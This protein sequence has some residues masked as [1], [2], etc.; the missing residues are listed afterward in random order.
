MSIGY[1]MEIKHFVVMKILF[2]EYLG[3]VIL[4]ADRNDQ[5]QVPINPLETTR[6]KR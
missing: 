1:I 5:E 4:D 6:I 3:S 2:I